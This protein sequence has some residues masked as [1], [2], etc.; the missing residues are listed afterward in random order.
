MKNPLRQD[1]WRADH[2][3]AGVLVILTLLAPRYVDKP[4]LFYGF[5]WGSWPVLVRRFPL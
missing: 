1:L 3:H 4:T 2:A 5:M